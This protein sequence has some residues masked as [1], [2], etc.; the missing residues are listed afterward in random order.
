MQ[1]TVFKNIH[2][3]KEPLY[4]D[5]S[6]IFTRIKKGN[7]KETIEAIRKC[8]NDTEKNELKKRLPSICFSGR[9]GERKAEMLIEHSGLICLDIDKVKKADLQTMKEKVCKN[10]YVFGCFVSPGGF[11]LKVIIKIAPERIHHKAQFLALEKRFNKILKGFTST[12]KNARK[13]GRKNVKIDEKQGDLLRVHIDQSGK[14]VGRVCYESYDP[15]IYQNKDSELW[16]ETLEETVIEQTIEDQDRTV[17]LLQIWIDKQEVYHEGNRNNYLS[18]FLY[19]MCR[20]GVSDYH[21]RKYL[22]GKFPGLPT[23]DLD[24]MIKSC[25]AK[26]DFGTVNFTEKER[27]SG[28]TQVKVNTTQ[29]VTAFWDMNDKGRVK[30][31]A[32]HFLKFIVASGFGIYRQEKGSSKWQFVH[33][34][35]MVVDIVDVLDIKRYVLDYILRIEAPAPVY[36][37]LQNKN[38]YFEKTYLNALPLVEVEQIRDE[39]DSSYI[40]FEDF[41]YR[42]SKG[43][44]EKHSYIDLKGKHIWR[45]QICSHT[46][47]EEV[48]YIEHDYATFVYRAMGKD[49]DRYKSAMAAIGYGIHTYKKKRLAKLIYAC[50]EGI[51]ELD[52]MASGG[53]GKNLYIECLR[54]VRSVVDID[55]KDLDKRDKFKFQMVSDDTQIICIDDYEGDAKEFF[56]KVTGHFEVE[57]KGQDK[58]AIEF[59]KSPKMYITSNNAP[60]GYSDSFARRI[61][62]VEFTNHYTAKHTPSD[63]FGDKDFFSDDWLQADW[64]ALYSFI[65]ACVKQYFKA[66][67]HQVELNTEI[68]KYKQLVKNTGIEFAEYFKEVEI[69]GFKLGKECYDE[70]RTESKDDLTLQ[71]FYSKLRRMC[72]IMGWQL[73]DNGGRGSE[74]KQI[75]IIKD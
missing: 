74:R 16:Y 61:T 59:S 50:D 35:N 14:D 12:Q 53:T 21:A 39:N 28:F 3:T 17:E 67:L 66:G 73:E 30:I 63:E 47:T 42:I 58:T 13:K 43:G 65:F 22:T 48:P 52:G 46:I 55:G 32:K 7:S 36:D 45:S 19:A 69:N 40:F 6:E 62:M 8:K 34:N 29:P 10:E 11:G 44:S 15:I 41:Y 18:K 38:R 20:Y 70:Y 2:D 23:S 49:M 54:Y 31:D 27:K 75:K 26:G 64:N 68:N 4:V 5:V 25:Y 71:A 24:A 1:V 72:A 33:I 37:E 60:R 56:A 57:K 9:F 51:G